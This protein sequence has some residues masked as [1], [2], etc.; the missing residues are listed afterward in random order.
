MADSIS[1]VLVSLT[2]PKDIDY[3]VN[4]AFG[5]RA[6]VTDAGG[7]GV[8]YIDIGFDK[9]LAASD[10]AFD[11][12]SFGYVMLGDGTAH[13]GDNYAYQ[14]HIGAYSPPGTYTITR[15]TI[16]DHAGNQA[17]YSTAQ[18][19]AL[20]IQ[21]SFTVTGTKTDTA[22]PTLTSLS[23]PGFVDESK[24]PAE[25]TFGASAADDLSGIEKVNITFDRGLKQSFDVNNPSIGYDY[26]FVTISN[27]ND[28][29]YDGQSS[30]TA[31]LVADNGVYN[32]DHVDVQDRAGNVAHYT[33]PELGAL[34]INTSMLVSDGSFTPPKV[35]AAVSVE[36]R[37]ATQVLGGFDVKLSA[38]QWNAGSNT[39]QA[40]FS[41]DQKLMW[42][43]GWTA[44]PAGGVSAQAWT[45]QSGAMGAVKLDATIANGGQKADFI[46]LHFKTT[47]VRGAFAL[48]MSGVSLNGVT[49][50]NDF[51]TKVDFIVPLL[52][53]G[54]SGADT[55]AGTADVDLLQGLEGNDTF[56]GVQ[57]DD[58][59]DGGAGI[60]IVRYAG[61][62]ADY[63]VVRDGA[64]LK[65]TAADGS[66]GAQLLTG[67]ER[68]AFADGDVAFDDAAAQLLRLYQAAFGRKPD[69]GGFSFWL[70]A[71]DHG[72]PLQTVAHDFVTS[73]ESHVLYGAAPA[74]AQFID[75]LYKNVLHRAG[76][77]DGARYWNN[78]L[79]HQLDTAWGV[80]LGF[81]ESSENRAQVADLVGNG[82]A[83]TPFG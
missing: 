44:G 27:A 29:W 33:A 56:T 28:P 60:D 65:V 43:D 11:L 9:P 37:T 19:T 77:A 83:Y 82:I 8:D 72:V 23:L 47:D 36:P 15:V 1:P 35:T 58:R 57:G 81:S 18:L 64:T 25:A 80:L 48:G 3:L 75:S 79:D 6:T 51:S 52:K 73:A 54:T 78:V 4:S 17:N 40:T 62:R 26:P 7:S 21:T 22:P 71:M 69:A 61:H 53:A 59:V 10:S 74:N 16:A 67:V 46:E 20:G 50:A 41:Y 24:G 49:L 14:G 12:F 70:D 42:F 13:A 2:L 45:T 66:G 31:M 63:H 68:I 5:V 32:I 55:L 39:F 34:G 38:D 30:A 76:D